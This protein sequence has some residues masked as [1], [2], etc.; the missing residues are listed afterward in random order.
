M[1]FVVRFWGVALD[2]HDDAVERLAR[3][4]GTEALGVNPQS[5][6]DVAFQ[7]LASEVWPLL[8][9]AQTGK[10]L[11]GQEEDN[12]LGYGPEGY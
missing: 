11:S 7:Y 12:I 5:R 3:R 4:S 9:S 8:G 10:P 1:F 6:G 2:F